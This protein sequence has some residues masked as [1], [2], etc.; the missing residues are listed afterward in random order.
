MEVKKAIIPAAGLGSRMFPL[1]KNTNKLMLPIINKPV[2]Q[3]LCE[4][5]YHSGIKEIIITG[6]NLNEI[7]KYFKKSKTLVEMTKN[8]GHKGSVKK[9][10]EVFDKCKIRF[11][12]QKKPRGWMHEIYLAKRWLKNDSF[13]VLFSDIIYDSKISALKQLVK[14]HKKTKLHIHSNG[15]YI[16]KPSV[17]KFINKQKF[18][19]GDDAKV[20]ASVL[21][22][23]DSKGEFLHVPIEG[24]VFDTGEPLDYIKAITHFTLKNK[25]IGPSYQQHIRE[26]AVKIKE[27]EQ[28]IQ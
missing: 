8:F 5:A 21:S 12:E 1:T 27:N 17:F 20:V 24:E 9:L 7:K 3:L 26:L 13:A 16:F 25:E 22:E 18:F 10:N 6:R 11:I 15:R 28:K 4:E 2:I 19:L 23:L 14:K